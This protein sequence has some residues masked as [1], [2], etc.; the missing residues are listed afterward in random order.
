[1]L[2]TLLGVMRGTPSNVLSIAGKEWRKK[3][4]RAGARMPTFFASAWCSGD[5]G[6]IRLPVGCDNTGTVF[7]LLNLSSKKQDL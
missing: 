6:R 4:A 7:S 2:S 3:N 1:M 5:A